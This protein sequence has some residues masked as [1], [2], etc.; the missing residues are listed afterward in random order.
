MLS[1]AAPLLRRGMCIVGLRP[2]CSTATESFGTETYVKTESSPRRSK[3]CFGID[4]HREWPLDGVGLAGW[5]TNFIF[6]ERSSTQ[7]HS[8]AAF[9]SRPLFEQPELVPW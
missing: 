8:R 7:G 1:E 4:T 6:P 3:S 5:A 9:G 2:M